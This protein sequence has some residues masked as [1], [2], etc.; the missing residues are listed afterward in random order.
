[1]GAA[2]YTLANASECLG[3]SVQSFKLKAKA[4]TS[5]EGS[6]MA[7]D[8]QALQR[9]ASV[10]NSRQ[11]NHAD[12]CA[13]GKV[14]GAGLARYS[15]D[16]SGG[17]EKAMRNPIFN[18]ST[19]TEEHAD[20]DYTGPT[21]AIQNNDSERTLCGIVPYE[22]ECARWASL[23]EHDGVV[24]CESCMSELEEHN[25]AGMY[26]GPMGFVGKA[27][28]VDGVVLNE[29]GWGVFDDSYE[30]FFAYG[31]HPPGTVLGIGR[32]LSSN[33]LTSWGELQ[34]TIYAHWRVPLDCCEEDA[35]YC[36]LAWRKTDESDPMFPS[37]KIVPYE[38]TV[39]RHE[40]WPLLDEHDMEMEY[41]C[42]KLRDWYSSST[43]LG[44]PAT[45][46]DF[47]ISYSPGYTI[48][49][50]TMGCSEPTCLEWPTS[51]FEEALSLLN[52][53]ES[54]G[55]INLKLYG[56]SC[57]VS[58]EELDAGAKTIIRY[59]IRK[60]GRSLPFHNFLEWYRLK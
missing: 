21:H 46:D 26:A 25:V 3:E 19:V 12:K 47:D 20:S 50:N 55:A 11:D 31:F 38:V 53:W 36:W 35:S 4:T 6:R 40:A 18:F 27:V 51:D 16:L 49:G 43:R 29:F 42:R 10:S 30:H 1:M 24:S 15:V 22:L 32:K 34:T 59:G 39:L 57:W 28:V 23:H 41:L 37:I 17:G 48:F 13:M 52:K 54:A 5:R 60:H 9:L 33:N 2:N 56:D 7:L 14:V 8:F 45:M 44:R 58:K